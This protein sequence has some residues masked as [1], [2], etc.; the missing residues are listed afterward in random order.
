M[1]LTNELL[2]RLDRQWRRLEPSWYESLSPGLSGAQMDE[3]TAPIGLTLPPEL[4]TWWGW[5]N[6]TPTAVNVT[7]EAQILSL[8][9]A[10]SWW[11]TLRDEAN[12]AAPTDPGPDRYW[13]AAYLPV[14]ALG[15]DAIATDCR[16]HGQS[17]PLFHVPTRWRGERN[18]LL[19]PSVGDVVHR[20]V[21]MYEGDYYAWHDE[22]GASGSWEVQEL[23]RKPARRINL[24]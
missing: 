13:P 4:R 12:E 24:I 3:L 11:Q 9:D 8:P 15:P 23:A 5:H 22:P 17:S 14:F 16:L 1:P 2:D 20:W 7:P 18:A 10:A 6:G 21:E 19:A